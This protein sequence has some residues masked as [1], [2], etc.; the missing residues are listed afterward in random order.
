VQQ[1]LLVNYSRKKRIVKM[2]KHFYSFIINLGL[3]ISGLLAVFS[4]LLI[5]VEYH[6][7][8]HGNIAINDHVFGISYYGWS[9]IHKIS[10]VIL[11]L[12]VIFHISLH[13]KWYKV[14]IKNRFVAKNMQVLTLSVVFILVAITGLIPWFIALLNGDVMLRKAF[15]ETH[16]KLAIILS[17]YLILHVIKRLKWFFNTFE[18]MINKHSTQLR[19]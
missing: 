9:D 12:L 18:K 16:D 11:S 10:I 13:W 7:G 5:Q 15:I 3:F 14:V 6:M 2:G 17:V 19:V 8:N 1:M 4:G